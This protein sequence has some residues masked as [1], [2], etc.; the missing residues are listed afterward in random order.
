MR[1]CAIQEYDRRYPIRFMYRALGVS[2]AVRRD[3]LFSCIVQTLNG[4]PSS[5]TRR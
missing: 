4:A 3:A 2:A 1:Y 5:L